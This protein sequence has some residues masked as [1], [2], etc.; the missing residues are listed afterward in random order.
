MAEE[1]CL[2][3]A[4]LT[5]TSTFPH[6]RPAPS[7]IARS[8]LGRADPPKIPGGFKR[9]ITLLGRGLRA[10]G[11]LNRGGWGWRGVGR[12]ALL[13][14]QSPLSPY[15]PSAAN[16]PAP[17][18][19]E[20]A[21][22]GGGSAWGLR[23]NRPTFPPRPRHRHQ[24]SPAGEVKTSRLFE[25]TLPGSFRTPSWLQKQIKRNSPCGG[26]SLREG[27]GAWGKE[28]ESRGRC[29]S[30]AGRRSSGVS[31]R[32]QPPNWYPGDAP[33]PGW[34]GG[35]A[36]SDPAPGRGRDRQHPTQ[37]SGTA[38]PVGPA[39]GDQNV[40]LPQECPAQW[41]GTG[42]TFALLSPADCLQGALQAHCQQNQLF[43]VSAGGLYN[44]PPACSPA[45]S[46]RCP[47]RACLIDN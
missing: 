18:R 13:G 19:Q 39:G 32:G 22:G 29:Q 12:E 38:L 17:G 35:S 1:K 24:H 8:R 33:A 46:W 9:E 2:R 31:E 3:G 11:R 42:R 6:C 25:M 10:R 7:C 47:P 28:A 14:E 37:L 36:A 45:L 27:Q 21:L 34:L 30:T 40:T 5:P 26:E 41:R 4:G 43:S 15:L 16:A 44:T 20:R 23:P